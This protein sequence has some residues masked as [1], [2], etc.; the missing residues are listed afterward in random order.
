MCNSHP[1]LLIQTTNTSK[2][3]HLYKALYGSRQAPRAWN[4]KLDQAFIKLGF[5]RCVTEHGMY[6]RGDAGER[7][8]VRVY[9]DDLIITRADT[10]MVGK[11]KEEM[12]SMFKMSHLGLLSYYLGIEVHPPKQG[13][14]ASQG[15]DAEKIL[16]KAR[17]TDCNPSRTLVEARLHLSKEGATPRVDDT[18]YRSLIGSLRYLVNTHPDLAYP[19]GYASRFMEKPREEH[20]NVVKCILRYVAGTKH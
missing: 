5:S 1:D 19:V 14:T 12:Q 6:I 4:T 2:V 16:E 11:F 17:L 9:V 13:I 18:S 8:I 10:D 3:L 7:L 20:M 15:A